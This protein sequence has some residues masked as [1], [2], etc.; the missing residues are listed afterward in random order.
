MRHGVEP[1]ERSWFEVLA[2]NLRP[3]FGQTVELEKLREAI[4]EKVQSRLQW[5]VIDAARMREGLPRLNNRSLSQ[6]H[7]DMAKHAL[8]HN[9]ARL[10]AF[11]QLKRLGLIEMRLAGKYKHYRD[12]FALASAKVWDGL[13]AAERLGADLANG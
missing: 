12:V 9:P 6:P 4:T 11:L 13:L 7:L 10:D 5:A 8:D 2:D 3:H 1:D